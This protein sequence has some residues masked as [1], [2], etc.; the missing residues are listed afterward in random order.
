MT[1]F[2]LVNLLN[3]FFSADGFWCGS[4]FLCFSHLV[5]NHWPATQNIIQMHDWF[6]INSTIKM[7]TLKIFIGKLLDAGG[8]PACKK[9]KDICLVIRTSIVI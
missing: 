3:F 8:V 7:L 2:T 4:Q 6:K 5:C 9:N 1:G